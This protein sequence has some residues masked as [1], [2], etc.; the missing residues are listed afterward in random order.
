MQLL[1]VGALAGKRNTGAPRSNAVPTMA[2]TMKCTRHSGVSCA[3][4]KNSW[5]ISNLLT[6]HRCCSALAIFSY[7]DIGEPKKNSSKG[8]DEDRLVGT[9]LLGAGQTLPPSTQV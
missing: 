1:T 5:R 2:P 9:D 6:I 3:T 8:A 4:L 7:N